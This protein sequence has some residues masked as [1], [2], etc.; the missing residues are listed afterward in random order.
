MFCFFRLFDLKNFG[1]RKNENEAET[2]AQCDFFFL[3][4]LFLSE[5][6]TLIM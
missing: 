4:S 5:T 2:K 6:Q 3:K 1:V